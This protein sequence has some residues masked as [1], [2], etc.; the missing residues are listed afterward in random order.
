[1][2]MTRSMML[3][4]TPEVRRSPYKTATIVAWAEATLSQVTILQ[5]IARRHC[6]SDAGGLSGWASRLA[7]QQP[8]PDR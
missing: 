7:N 3:R 2:A 5:E 8:Q 1:M 6:H 4:F